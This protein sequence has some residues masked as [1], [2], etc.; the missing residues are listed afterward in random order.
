MSRETLRT[1]F[2]GL[3]LAAALAL[4]VPAPSEAAPLRRG[5]PGPALTDFVSRWIVGLL[6]KIGIEITSAGS[7]TPPMGNG[8]PVTT[9]GDGGDVGWHIDPNG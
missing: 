4:A 2:I 3:V 7:T 8:G 1:L 6:E 9:D 5:D